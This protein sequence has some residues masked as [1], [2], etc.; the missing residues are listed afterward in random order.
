MPVGKA[1]REWPVYQSEQ[2]EREQ[3]E[4]V[5]HLG[6]GELKVD[7]WG[8]YAYWYE[9][10]P[11]YADD[12]D[13]DSGMYRTGIVAGGGYLSQPK[14]TI[15]DADGQVWKLVNTYASSGETECNVCGNGTGDTFTEG[16]YEEYGEEPRPTDRCGLCENEVKD[17]P[18]FIYVGEGY[19]AVYQ[20]V[21]DEIIGENLDRAT[22]DSALGFGEYRDSDW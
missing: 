15:T 12:I 4:A 19:E 17:M 20:L 13:K 16:F 6:G 9:G 3:V 18:G 7:A 1:Y 10:S 22:D 5:F 8:G 14:E 2:K 11:E 21:E